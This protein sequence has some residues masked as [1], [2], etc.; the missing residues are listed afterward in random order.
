M[1][2]VIMRLEEELQVI[3][4]K[5]KEYERKSYSILSYTMMVNDRIEYDRLIGQRT[6]IEQS[7][8][9][10]KS[11]MQADEIARLTKQLEAKSR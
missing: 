2:D 10:T 7:I 8:S 9:I 4:E 5:I 11:E 1:N 3:N 6:A